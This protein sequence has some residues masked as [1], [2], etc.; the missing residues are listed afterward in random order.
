MSSKSV[1]GFSCSDQVS[2]SRS[3]T[4]LIQLQYCKGAS[5]TFS[6]HHTI[7]FF[8][9]WL[10]L[11]PRH[12]ELEYPVRRAVDY[13]AEYLKGAFGDASRPDF[14]TRFCMFWLHRLSQILVSRRIQSS[15]ISTAGWKF[16]WLRNS[17]RYYKVGR[18]DYCKKVFG[19]GF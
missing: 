1:R 17:I 4:V 8:C 11:V 16:G 19:L 10:N 7:L 6:S 9:S 2:E 13:A 15:K 12:T 18:P 5:H 3:W 14:A